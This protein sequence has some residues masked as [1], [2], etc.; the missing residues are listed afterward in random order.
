MCTPITSEPLRAQL[1]SILDACLTDGVGAW[2]MASDGRYSKP[3]SGCSGYVPVGDGRLA[4][5]SAEIGL[6]AALI[7]VRAA[8]SP[9]SLRLFPLLGGTKRCHFVSLRCASTA[10]NLA[11]PRPPP[12][13]SFWCR[14]AIRFARRRRG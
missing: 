14:F 9:S 4:R 12:S 8:A 7:E 2:G 3:C 6:H 10:L 13:L 11:I 5:R 1:Q